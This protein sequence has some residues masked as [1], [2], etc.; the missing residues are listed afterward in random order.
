[1]SENCWFTKVIPSCVACSGIV[2]GVIQYMEVVPLKTALGI[3]KDKV[4]NQTSL[5]KTTKPY[6]DLQVLYLNEKIKREMLDEKIKGSARLE[7]EKKNLE[8]ELKSTNN[9]LNKLEKFSDY[10]TI[11][12]KLSST[13]SSLFEYK[14]AYSLVAN[15]NKQLKSKLSLDDDLKEL[16]V[17][18]DHFETILDC[19]SNGCRFYAYLKYAN[20]Y[21]AVAFE[22][23][24]HQLD[25]TNKQISLLHTA[26]SKN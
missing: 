12:L 25:E 22:Q 13:E 8:L 1:M 18:A 21:E 7:I 26:L 5:V 16:N 15:E 11:A 24:K 17:K 10:E 9:K 6:Q 3:E 20:K 23:Y 19:M 4:K 14:E 2:F